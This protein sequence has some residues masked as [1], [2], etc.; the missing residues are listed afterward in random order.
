MLPL[1]ARACALVRRPRQGRAWMSSEQAGG[2]CLGK[3]GIRDFPLLPVSRLLFTPVH[4]RWPSEAGRR[5]LEGSGR[6]GAS[7]E[8][9]GRRNTAPRIR[10]SGERAGCATTLLLKSKPEGNGFSPYLQTS[11]KFLFAFILLLLSSEAPAGIRSPRAR[12]CPT[13]RLQAPSPRVCSLTGPD[14]P[15]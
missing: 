7:Q 10:S 4:C 8:A 12:H 14:R 6:R 3:R 13:L 5:C 9:A 15:N 1:L 2:G 11:Q